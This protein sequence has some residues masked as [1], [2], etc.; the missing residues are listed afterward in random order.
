[1]K[2]ISKFGWA[3][4]PHPLYNPDMGPSDF[5]LF[6]PMKGL[7]GQHFPDNDTIITAVRKWVSSA[8]TEFYEC[9]M[10]P[11]VHHWLK[12]ITSGGGYM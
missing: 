8:G 12:C 11:L 7:C 1:M 5:H 10:Q 6:R 2:H 4:L 3:V 9:N